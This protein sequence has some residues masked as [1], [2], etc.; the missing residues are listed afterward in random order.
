MFLHSRAAGTGA[1]AKGFTRVRVWK[2]RQGQDCADT[3]L[4][5]LCNN[6]K[7][8]NDFCFVVFSRG[9]SYG[10]GTVS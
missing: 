3:A 7:D 4:S 9:Q 6:E 10:A 2:N 8:C 5:V 1:R